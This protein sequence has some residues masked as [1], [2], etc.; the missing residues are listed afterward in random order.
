M[1]SRLTDE[2]TDGTNVTGPD[3]GLQGGEVIR[4][5]ELSFG[6]CHTGKAHS[7]N[8]IMIELPADKA[9]FTGDIVTNKRIQSARPADSD[10]FGQI[11]VVEVAL[12]TNRRWFLPGHGYSGAREIAEQQMLLLQQ[13]LGAVQR[14]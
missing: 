12:A 9:L 1:F 6:I 7:D 10:I 11:R 4:I 2:A 13:P 3:I 8:D 5:G 14:Y